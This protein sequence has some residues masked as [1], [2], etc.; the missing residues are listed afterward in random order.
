MNWRKLL[1]FI[2]AIFV[3][4][5]L[6]S[7]IAISVKYIG[8][9]PG[10]PI[11]R[12]VGLFFCFVVASFTYN[13]IK[14]PELESEVKKKGITGAEISKRLE[15]KRKT[16]DKNS[17]LKTEI[18]EKDSHLVNNPEDLIKNDKELNIDSSANI[19]SKKKSNYKTNN[20]I[21]LNRPKNEQMDM[22]K[23][24]EAA[25]SPSFNQKDYQAKSCPVYLQENKKE[26]IHGT[27]CTTQIEYAS[28]LKR[29]MAFLIDIIILTVFMGG[30]LILLTI[31][32]PNSDTTNFDNCFMLWVIISACASFIYF[33]L[34]NMTGQSCGKMGLKIKVVSEQNQKLS[35]FQSFLR[36]LMLIVDLMPYFIPGLLALIVMASS[37]KNQRLGDIITKTIVIE[38]KYNK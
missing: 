22:K 6:V 4:I 35:L 11:I 14:G 21:I 7:V 29:L 25:F 3:F 27:G 30:L 23:S 36:T 38:S 37:E 2:M 24:S 1:G 20:E 17:V 32:I 16:L 15:K 12:I 28:L 34:F 18:F 5:G 10:N 9:E 8:Q 33:V 19:I 26:E 31:I 13:I